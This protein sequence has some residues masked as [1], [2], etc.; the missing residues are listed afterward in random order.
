MFQTRRSRVLGGVLLVAA[1]QVGL[2]LLVG[3]QKLY[4]A[5]P[6][7]A[8]E[9]MRIYQKHAVRY[10]LAVNGKRRPLNL[11]L[12]D[13]LV[14][15]LGPRGVESL[16][17]RLAPWDVTLFTRETAPPQFLAS[18]WKCDGC[19]VFSVRARFDSPLIG[20]AESETW[21]GGLGANGFTNAMIFFLGGWFRVATWQAWVA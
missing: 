17:Q 1:C 10:G 19:Q 18:K 21:W 9:V 5:S 4:R 12:S 13:E 2:W 15:Q 6:D 3:R 16:G 11:V 7:L 14:Q 20:V 8:E